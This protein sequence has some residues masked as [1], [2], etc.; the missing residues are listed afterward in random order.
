MFTG[1]FQKAIQQSGTVYN[2]WAIT[3]N[4]KEV[5]FQIGEKLGYAGKDPEALVEFLKQQP[6]EK[7]A[8][9]HWEVAGEKMMVCA[10]H[11]Y[12]NNGYCALK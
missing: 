6:V 7:F 4:P 1:L 11:I 10:F 3:Y 12:L 8:T 5:A 2:P 9:A